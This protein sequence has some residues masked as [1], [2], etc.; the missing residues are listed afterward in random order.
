MPS[1]IRLPSR[2][3]LWSKENVATLT[4]ASRR[5][6]VGESGALESALATAGFQ[7]SPFSNELLN[8]D[9]LIVPMHPVEELVLLVDRL[10]GP[11]GCPWDQAQTHESLKKHLIEETYEVIESIDKND[12]ENLREELGDLLLQPIMHG[13]I[14]TSFKTSDV[15]KEI[16]DKLIRRHPNVFGEVQ[17][18]GSDDVLKIWDAIKKGEKGDSAHQSVLTGIPRSLPSLLRAFEVSKRAARQGFEWES[19]EGVWDKVDEEIQELKAATSPG[20]VCSEI[21]DLLF[22]IVNI[23]RWMKVEPEEALQKMLNRF[24]ERFMHMEKLA[25]HE[26]S[27]LSPEEWDRLWNLA[28]QAEYKF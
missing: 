11:G 16:V 25:P 24:T 27:S 17:V 23:A 13:Q 9:A 14:A 12:P 15:A 19:I 6:L 22:T 18:E 26:L 5:F 20:E 4:S 28:K 8:E 7:L 3:E 1:I 2:K 21:G 10:L